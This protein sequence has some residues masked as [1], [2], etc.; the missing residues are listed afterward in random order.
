[1]T[2]AVTE[3][4]RVL[5]RGPDD[6]YSCPDFVQL[7]EALRSLFPKLGKL[8][9]ALGTALGSSGLPCG[10]HHVGRAWLSDLISYRLYEKVKVSC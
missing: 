5:P 9:L 7:K 6:P 3:L 1:M 8:M 10:R 4:W 2:R